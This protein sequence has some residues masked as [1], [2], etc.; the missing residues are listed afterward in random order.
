MPG[1]QSILSLILRE[2][3][4][5]INLLTRLPQLLSELRMLGFRDLV[6]IVVD[7]IIDIKSFFDNLHQ[8]PVPG[9]RD[10]FACVVK[11]LYYLVT[12]ENLNFKEY[13]ILEWMFRGLRDI[14]IKASYEEDARIRAQ[15][16]NHQASPNRMKL[17]ILVQITPLFL[18]QYLVKPLFVIFGGLRWLWCALVIVVIYFF[19]SLFYIQLDLSKQ[20]AV[21][22]LL[23]ISYYLLLSGFNTFLNKYRYGK[24]T[25]AIQR[26]W[27]RTGIVFW[28]IEGF[29]FLLFFYYFLN[30]SQEPLYM[31]DYSNLNQEFLIQ[32]K[33][34]YKNLILLSLAI[35]LSFILLLNINFFIYL[36]SILILLVISGLITYMLYV[37]SYQFVYIISLFSDNDWVFNKEDGAWVLEIEENGLR[38]KQ[39]YFVLCLVAKY[40]HFIFIFISWFFFL[41]KCIEVNS[42]SITMLGYNTQNLLI[43]YV[44]NFFCLIQ[45]LKILSKKFLEITYSNFFI[46]YDEKVFITTLHEF[47]FVLKHY[48]DLNLPSAIST[49]TFT[50]LKLYSIN[51]SFVWKL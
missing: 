42:I 33:T 30:S 45:W 3:R 19:T 49:N 22:Y 37:E 6:S 14:N 1:F 41:I 25:S 35:W 31:F 4:K 26:F 16:S 15:S 36:Q 50:L 9:F 7:K 34:S 8:P 24:F 29:L 5:A 10:L 13:W 27:K 2:I 48:F 17:P 11:E 28:L 39:Q 18:N 51:D 21:W 43:L 46:Q 32:L 44:L 40:W 20:I 47:W 38:V 12:K 23:F